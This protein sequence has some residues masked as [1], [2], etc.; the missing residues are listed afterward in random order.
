MFNFCP[1]CNNMLYIKNNNLEENE[2]SETHVKIIYYCRHCSYNSNTDKNYLESNI[3]SN[4]C[5]YDVKYRQDDYMF[6]YFNNRQL[7]CDPT[8]PRLKNIK[9]INPEC[10][11]NKFKEHSNFY[12]ILDIIN[13]DSEDEIEKDESEDENNNTTNATN[14]TIQ[15]IVKQIKSELG[16][17]IVWNNLEDNKFVITISKP[18]GGGDNNLNNNEDLEKI[19]DLYREDNNI[20]CSKVKIIEHNVIFIKYDHVNMKYLYLCTNCNTSWKNK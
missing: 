14:I 2:N 9:C 18:E 16:I 3:K 11:T 10:L 19:N 8:L 12:M 4:R 20:Y 5:L 13:D 1:N 17:T 6:K 15:K 7:T